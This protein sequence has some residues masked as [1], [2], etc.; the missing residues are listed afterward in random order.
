ME[1][2]AASLAASTQR[3]VA[4][5][6]TRH[7][8]STWRSRGRA[9]AIGALSL[10]LLSA[11]AGQGSGGGGA[12]DPDADVTI[13]FWNPLNGPDRPA[14]EQVISDFNA[15]QDRITIKNNA[16]P[17]DVMYQ[18]LLTAISSDNGPDLVAI[19]AGR[20]PSFADKGALQ[21]IDDFY[22]N[23]DY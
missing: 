4:M 3:G 7:P 1:V 10:A 23:A 16:Q 5:S 6:S 8:A 18:K 12:G 14:V 9:L 22:D 19:H 2:S 17:S 21:P 13:D 20:I 11:C 15:S